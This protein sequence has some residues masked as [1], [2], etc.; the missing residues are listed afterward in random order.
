V[1]RQSAEKS[2]SETGCS[3][4]R[5]GPS[6]PRAVVLVRSIACMIDH[7]N[8][9]KSAPGQTSRSN[10]PYPVPAFSTRHISAARVVTASCLALFL[11]VKG[12]SGAVYPAAALSHLATLSAPFVLVPGFAQ[13]TQSTTS[14]ALTQDLP[15]CPNVGKTKAITS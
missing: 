12:T 4:Q 8:G 2:W 14:L 1:Q 10:N 11:L 13:H 3:W 7:L 15:L 6:A 5:T 9:R